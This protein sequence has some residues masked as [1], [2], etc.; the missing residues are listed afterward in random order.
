MTAIKTVYASAPTDEVIIGTLEII[1][2][3][4]EP[5]RISSDF[6][7]H[8]FGVD[9]VLQLFEQGPLSIALPSKDTK[10][11]QTLSFG[12][13]GVSGRAQRYVDAA[14]ESGEPAKMIYREYLV[15]DPMTPA[16]RPIEMTI[17]GGYFEG[18]D[19][20]FEGGYYDLLNSAW[21][22][23]RY[24]SITAPGIRYM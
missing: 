23:E 5:F 9:G 18:A 1:A 3:G 10:G 20:V 14:L 4:L 15:S 19:A 2:P 7:D 24:T 11:N 12:V 17:N 22:R 21:P 16:R 13:S 8:Y 6:E